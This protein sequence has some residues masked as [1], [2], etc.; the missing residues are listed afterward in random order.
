MNKIWKAI[1]WFFF[2][3]GWP[4]SIINILCIQVLLI[5]LSG[6][7]IDATKKESEYYLV[8]QL[9]MYVSE[10]EFPDGWHFITTYW[11]TDTIWNN[12][13]NQRDE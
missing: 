8:P 3:I 9:E 12:N 7:I 4:H 13:Q 5:M 11:V 6:V 1:S 2:D 10:S